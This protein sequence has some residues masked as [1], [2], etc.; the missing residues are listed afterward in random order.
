MKEK[1]EILGVK[2][3]ALVEACG[4]IR[5]QEISCV[6]ISDG[7]IIHAADGRGV[8]PLLALYHQEREKLKGNCVVD[9]II[10]KAAAMILVLGGARAAYGEIMSAAACAYLAERGIP[11]QYGE[12][13]EVVTNQAGTGMCPIEDSVIAIDSP[14]EGRAAMARRIEELRKAARSE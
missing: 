12:Y 14:E 5:T 13:I 10:G 4:M 8:S 7:E 1:A 6:V 11:F 2:E 3:G 9:R